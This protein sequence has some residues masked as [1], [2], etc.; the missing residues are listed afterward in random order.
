MAISARKPATLSMLSRARPAGKHA[1]VRNV[2]G[3]LPVSP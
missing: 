1:G 3:F 2:Q